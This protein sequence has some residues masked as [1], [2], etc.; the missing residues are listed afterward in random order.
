VLIDDVSRQVKRGLAAEPGI[1][2]DV[3]SREG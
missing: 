3:V 2:L 1:Y